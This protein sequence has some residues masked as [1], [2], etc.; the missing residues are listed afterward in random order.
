M[1]MRY[2]CLFLKFSTPTNGRNPEFYPWVTVLVNAGYWSIYNGGVH[3][4]PHNLQELTIFGGCRQVIHNC[5]N[6]WLSSISVLV[7]LDIQTYGICSPRITAIDTLV[8]VCLDT[9][10]IVILDKWSRITDL[11]SSDRTA[12]HHLAYLD[13]IH[14][15]FQCIHCDNLSY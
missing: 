3:S 8:T 12:R 10:F 13:S 11:P 14:I 2:T 6:A 7:Q 9:L 1:L 15:R 5:L 4:S